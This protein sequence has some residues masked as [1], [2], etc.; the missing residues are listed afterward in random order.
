M[1]NR[2]RTTSIAE[3]MGDKQVNIATTTDDD[4]ESDYSSS[5]HVS[6]EVNTYYKPQAGIYTILLFYAY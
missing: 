5:Y 6:E 3:D 2:E 1:T 4:Q